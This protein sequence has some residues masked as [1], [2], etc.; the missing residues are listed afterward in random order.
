[1][2]FGWWLSS[3]LIG[4]KAVITNRFELGTHE[5]RLTV[6]DLDVTS[7][8]TELFDVITPAEAAEELLAR[9]D[10]MG[11]SHRQKRPLIV[12]LRATATALERH[13]SEVALIHL[14]ALKAKIRSQLQRTAPDTC[15]SLCAM[16]DRLI[17]ALSTSLD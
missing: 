2:E 17:Q 7:T 16:T 4:A 11:L 3:Q 12:T 10:E 5:V 14:Q 8:E 15:E 13:E 1:L 6:G 9:I